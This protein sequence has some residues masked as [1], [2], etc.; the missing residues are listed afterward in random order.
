[1]TAIYVHNQD[2]L[3]DALNN[4][5]YTYS[6]R[7]IIID[8]PDGVWLEVITRHYLDVRACRSSTV[9]AY[10][11]STVRAY[12]SSTVRAYGSSTVQAYGSSTVQAYGSSTVQAYESSTVQAYGSSTVQ[13][14]GSSTVQAYELSTVQAYGS[15]TVRAYESST[16]QAYGSSTVQAYESSTVTA[17]SLVAVHLFSANATING[18]VIIDVS[19]IDDSDAK[20]WADYYGAEINGDEVF[21]YKALS[22]DLISG[23]TYGPGIKWPTSGVV[24]CNDWEPT[25]ECGGGLHL[26]PHPHQAAAYCEPEAERMLL[27]SVKMDDICPIPTST[28]PKCKVQGVTVLREVALDGGDLKEES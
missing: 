20:Q 10:G 5:K 23:K 26:S 13:A 3:D 27:C 22:E 17:G 9:R 6:D 14:Y 15:S 18:G 16:V 8:S 25:N 11:S 19:I 21:L 2:E 28:A 1:M 24:S 4:P 7:E 12:G